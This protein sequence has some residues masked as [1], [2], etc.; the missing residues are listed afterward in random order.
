MV[1][2]C[3]FIC[4]VFVMYIYGDIDCLA[5]HTLCPLVVCTCEIFTFIAQPVYGREVFYMPQCST[6]HFL[7]IAKFALV[8]SLCQALYLMTAVPCLPVQRSRSR[9]MSVMAREELCKSEILYNAYAELNVPNYGVDI[10][11]PS[12][13]DYYTVNQ[14]RKGASDTVSGQVDGNFTLRHYTLTLH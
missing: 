10:D 14:A 4:K 8:C 5:L 12:D 3:F 13:V 9:S 2:S 1:Y 11:I 7:V 6:E